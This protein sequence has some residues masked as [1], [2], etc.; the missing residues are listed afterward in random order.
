MIRFSV[1]DG[2]VETIVVTQQR[3]SSFR[4]D[5]FVRLQTRFPRM[6]TAQ[7]EAILRDC[8]EN[9][10]WDGILGRLVLKTASCYKL[11]PCQ[12]VAELRQLP[13]LRPDWQL[14]R[15]IELERRAG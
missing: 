9:N 5:L 15:E 1:F 8:L 7:I 12:V 13:R 14:R 6:G 11:L 2:L 4:L 3:I 10:V